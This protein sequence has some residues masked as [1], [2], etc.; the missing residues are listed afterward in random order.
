MNTLNSPLEAKSAL[1]AYLAALEGKDLQ[2]VTSLAGDRTLVEIPFLKPTRLVG[3][4]EISSGHIAIFNSLDHLS[5]TIDEPMENNHHA[6]AEGELRVQR[7]SGEEYTHQIGI[8]AE[9]DGAILIRLSLYG[10]ARNIRLWS[11]KTIL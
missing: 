10:D 6:I 4:R 2:G 3:Q 5:F 8:V 9:T 7:K 1:L 11:D